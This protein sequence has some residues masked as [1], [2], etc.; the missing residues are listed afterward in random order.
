MVRSTSNTDNPSRSLCSQEADT[1]YPPICNKYL[2][3]R[4]IK[5]YY[6]HLVAH[7]QDTFLS[8]NEYASTITCSSCFRKTKKQTQTLSNGSKTLPPFL[9]HYR[10]NKYIILFVN[11]RFC[12]HAYTQVQLIY[13]LQLIPVW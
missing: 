5:P 10:P 9:S 6:S 2:T 1:V 13:Y 8:T 4:S 7:G 12:S 3:R 11:E